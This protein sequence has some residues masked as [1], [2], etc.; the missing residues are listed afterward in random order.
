MK[1]KNNVKLLLAMLGIIIVL[2][3][4]SVY[5]LISSSNYKELV[6]D[7]RIENYGLMFKYKELQRRNKLLYAKIDYIQGRIKV[8]ESKNEAMD[9]ERAE[10]KKKL[11]ELMAKP[12]PSYQ[13]DFETCKSEYAALKQKFNLALGLV[14]KTESQLNLCYKTE[15]NYKRKALLLEA[16]NK[17]LKDQL[18]DKSIEAENYRKALKE[19]DRSWKKRTLLKGFKWA[20]VGVLAGGALMYIVALR[21]NNY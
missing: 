16:V 4:F 21:Q 19:L 2:L 7:L 14:K 1:A 12:R 5:M 3:T 15:K 9:K 13:K 8:L 18:N 6:K 20:L 10:L 17:N 11:G